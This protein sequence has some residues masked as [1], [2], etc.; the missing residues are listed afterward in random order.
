MKKTKQCWADMKQRCYNPNSQ[1]YK[2][3]GLRGIFVCTRWLE[4]FENFLSD[5]GNKPDGLTLERINTNGNYEPANCKWADSFEQAR[6][7]RTTHKFEFDGKYMTMREWAKHLG[8]HESTLSSRLRMGYPIEM[9][10][11]SK[12]LHFGNIN[13]VAAMKESQQ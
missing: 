8:R 2:N 5:M 12:C 3:Y 10:L 1:Q 9:I 13:A 11:S 7:K 4:S 6:N